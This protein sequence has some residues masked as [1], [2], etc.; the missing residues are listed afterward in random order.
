MYLT[1]DEYIV[2][3]GTLDDSTFNDLAFGA[4]VTINYATFNRLVGETV[5]PKAVYF[6]CREGEA[7]MDRGNTKQEI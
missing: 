2:F 5:I 7:V 4:E 3:G 6:H 1:Y